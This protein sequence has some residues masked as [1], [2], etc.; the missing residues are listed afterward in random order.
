M[1]KNNILR[2]HKVLENTHNGC[3][4]IK[5]T[6]TPYSGIIISYGAVSFD[7]VGDH[8]KLKFD[9]EVHDDAGIEY[10]KQELEQYLG[11][12]LQELIVWGIHNNDLT[13]TGGV[14][15][16]RTGDPIEPDSE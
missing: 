10:D 3:Q 16:N 13:Y 14:D 9:Y 1:M 15:E 6:E 5:L 8:I 2:P 11:D 7:E 4:A 12:F